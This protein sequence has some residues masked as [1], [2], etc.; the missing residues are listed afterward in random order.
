M[1]QTRSWFRMQEC[2]V[3]GYDLYCPSSW[4]VPGG[5]SLSLQQESLCAR[6]SPAFLLVEFY[7]M[8]V[9]PNQTNLRLGSAH[10][11]C[12][13]TNATKIR[14]KLLIRTKDKVGK[15]KVIVQ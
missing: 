10:E 14:N 4:K 2:K 7:G 13:C 3:Y 8:S 6:E 15:I 11:K 12:N 1:K 5:K 9:L